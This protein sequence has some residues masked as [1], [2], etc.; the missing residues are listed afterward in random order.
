MALLP[1]LFDWDAMNTLP[2]DRWLAIA[3]QFYA[4][5]YADTPESRV[6][7]DLFDEAWTMIMKNVREVFPCDVGPREAYTVTIS[8]SGPVFDTMDGGD[9]LWGDNTYA[10]DDLCDLLSFVICQLD[11]YDREGYQSAEAVFTNPDGS[12]FEA[13]LDNYRKNKGV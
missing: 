9:H 10:S 2:E 8:W 11:T 7:S 3:N 6:W 4:T 12:T 1:P 13:T 5:R